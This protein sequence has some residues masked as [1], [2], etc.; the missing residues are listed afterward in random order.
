MGKR[1]LKFNPIVELIKENYPDELIILDVMFTWEIPK[2]LKRK[3]EIEAVTN[4]RVII[5]GV[6]WRNAGNEGYVDL[7]QLDGREYVSPEFD[8]QVTKITEGCPN[9]CSFC[10]SGDFKVLGVPKFK[11]NRVLL[12]DENLLAHPQIEDVLRE[13]SLVRLNGKV[14]YYEAI[15]GFE[16]SRLTLDVCELLKKARFGNIRFAWDE[17][18]TMKSQTIAYAT[19][20]KLMSVGYA[21]EA[22]SIFVLTNWE[23]GMRDCFK[24]MD[25]MKVWGVKINDCCYNC[26]YSDPVSEGW[27]LEEIRKFRKG[28]REHNLVVKYKVF[29]EERSVRERPVRGREGSLMSYK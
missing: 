12:T 18:L 28:A 6:G 25:L 7:S 20:K 27:E 1:T 29:P 24:K 2:A 5:D 26:N 8:Y 23:V 15:C 11:R 9:S 22:I 3:A 16:K 13:L 21:P 19:I 14:V 4:E 10:F 17:K